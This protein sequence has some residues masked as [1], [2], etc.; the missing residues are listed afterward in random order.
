MDL[1]TRW[2][3]VSVASLLSFIPPSHMVVPSRE[4]NI[5]LSHYNSAM[6]N[7]MEVN[8]ISEDINMDKPRSRSLSSSPNVSRGMSTHSDILSIPY[9]NRIEAQNND[10]LVQSN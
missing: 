6:S 8:P 4:M 1:N 10:P 7:L 9:V 3:T 5:N 2:E